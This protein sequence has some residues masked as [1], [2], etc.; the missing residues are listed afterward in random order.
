MISCLAQPLCGV[1]KNINV[2][3]RMLRP[4]LNTEIGHNEQK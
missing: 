2:V 3:R 4:S 1:S